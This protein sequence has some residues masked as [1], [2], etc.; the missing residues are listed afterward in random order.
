M[1]C[2]STDAYAASTRCHSSST[3]VTSVWQQGSRS[4]TMEQ[5]FSIG[6]RNWLVVDHTAEDAPVCDAASRVAG[7]NNVRDESPSC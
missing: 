2:T 5:T 3:I 1:S 6:E 4:T 7:S